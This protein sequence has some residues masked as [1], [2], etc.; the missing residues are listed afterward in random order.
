[1]ATQIPVTTVLMNFSGIYPLEGFHPEGVETLDFT[2]LEGTSCY[3]D[4]AAALAIRDAMKAF[5]YRGIHWLDSGD[6]HYASLFWLEKVDVPFALVL[7]DNHPDDQ[8]PAFGGEALSCGSW[9]LRARR[10]PMLARGGFRHVAGPEDAAV[11]D[12]ASF[13]PGLP[14]YLSIDKDL[15]CAD[16]ARTDWD[17]GTMT[18]DHLKCVI[19]RIASSHSIIG[20]D[21]CGELP[22]KKGAVDIDLIINRRTNDILQDYL[23]NLGI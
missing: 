13:C 12:W 9:V 3:C 4:D 5:G 15:L 14:V 7:L 20:T 16:D 10:L 19:D 1:M 17:Q 8:A 11:A 18:L 21:V 6:Y 23:L 2:S 22:E